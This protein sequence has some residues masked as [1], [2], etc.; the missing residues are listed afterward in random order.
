MRQFN[1]T[2]EQRIVERTA[3]LSALNQ[4]LESFVYLVSH[5]LKAPL[6]GVEGYS[7]LL[8]EDYGEQLD[9]E[10]RLFVQNIRAG[11]T[12]MNELITDLLTYSRMER[13]KLEPAMLDLAALVDQ[14]LQVCAQEIAA[15]R[16]KVVS[17]LS[18]L[19]VYGDREGILLVL[20][21]LLE[22]AIKFSK[23]AVHPRIELGA[24][25]DDQSVTLWVRDNGIG[26]DMK[27]NQ[28][29]FEIFE[30]LHR[31]EDYP[32]TGIG[33]AL[34]R[35]AMERMGGSVWAESTPGQGATFFLRLPAESQIQN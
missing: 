13:R 1:A 15:C 22:N 33:L 12:R 2:L 34:V 6:R 4:S 29:I 14:A 20:R 24:S 31:Q 27:Y 10:G 3:E 18:A 28:R 21:N 30:R 23:H 8:Q 35:K 5:D 7:R 11:V 16:I 9:E 32:G 19:S 25:H 17:Q 26:F